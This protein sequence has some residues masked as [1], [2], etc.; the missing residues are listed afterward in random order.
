LAEEKSEEW[1]ND[2]ISQGK[3][4]ENHVHAFAVKDGR[5]G[6]QKDIPRGKRK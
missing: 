1:C 3:K 2:I 4:A 6:R 5:K